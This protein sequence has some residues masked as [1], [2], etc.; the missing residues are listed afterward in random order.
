MK[1][2]IADDD[3]AFRRLVK[4]ILVQWGYD[5]VIADNG[6]DALKILQ[7]E[8]SPRLAALDWMMPGMLQRVCCRFC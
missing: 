3:Y 5:V 4:T 7:S 1:I 2:L 8:Y 6:D